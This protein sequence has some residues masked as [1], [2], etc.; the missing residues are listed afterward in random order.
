MTPTL[1]EGDL[2]AGRYRVGVKIGEG[3]MQHVHK[4]VDTMLD[5]NV[6]LKCPKTESAE[7]RF[8]TSAQLSARINHP[9]VASTLD[10]VPES[11]GGPYLI[12]EFIDGQDLAKLRERLPYFDPYLVAHL[13]HHFARA[14]EA[15]HNARVVHRDLK[16]NNVM[17]SRGFSLGTI[18]LTDFGIARMAQDVMQ[19]LV[20]GGAD[21]MKTSSTMKTALA[22]MSPENIEKPS[23]A[24]PPAD[25]WAIGAICFDLL[26]GVKPYGDGLLVVRRIFHESRAAFPDHLRTAQF[27]GLLDELV[28]LID[29]CMEKDVKKRITATDL[30]KACDQLCY[31]ETR[32]VTGKVD[33]M[34]GRSRGFI[35]PDDGG[36]Q[37]FFHQDSVYGPKVT[38]GD[39]VCVSHYPGTPR[40]R[41]HPI[42]KLTP[43]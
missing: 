14:V 3:G 16:P 5:R 12:E 33:Y 21:S 6:V 43:P 42:I 30:R 26:S 35:L 23:E 13:M 22:Y 10:Y 7:K 2:V 4:A 32:R 17:L 41:A 39:H 9:N 40:E 34:I 20:D 8:N 15:S 25:V 11:E 37:I 1:V 38:T 19:A 36:D 31:P 29:R 27:I 28:V 18:K 24:G